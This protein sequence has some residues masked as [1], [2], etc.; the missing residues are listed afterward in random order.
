MAFAVEY[1]M[2]G[3]AMEIGACVIA[4]G[5]GLYFQ[6]IAMIKC[7]KQSLFTIS[8]NARSENQGKFDSSA[9]R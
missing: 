9:K 3:F 4:L 1:I 2:V 5:L 7:I 8:Q 6:F